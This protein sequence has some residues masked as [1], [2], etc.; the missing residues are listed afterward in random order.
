M[1]PAVAMDAKRQNAAARIAAR[2]VTIRLKLS[3][4]FPDRTPNE[5]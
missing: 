1:G 3:W 4:R 5:F 2:A